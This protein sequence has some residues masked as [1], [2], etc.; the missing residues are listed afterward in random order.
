LV[1]DF[2]TSYIPKSGSITTVKDA[3]SAFYASIEQ[4]DLEDARSSFDIWSCGIIL[5]TLMAKKEPYTQLSVVKRQKA[6]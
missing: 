5:Y 4:L 3:M 1:T 2:G 6:I